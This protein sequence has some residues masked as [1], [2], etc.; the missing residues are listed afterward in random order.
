MTI[1]WLQRE[2]VYQ[3]P[4]FTVRKDTLRLPDGKQ[5]I[6]DVIDH[7]D[8]VTILPIDEEGNILFVRQYRQPIED[9][10]LELPAGV[11]KPGEDPLQCAQRELREET[12]MGANL[13]TKLGTFYLAPGYSSEFMHVYLARDLYPSPL[14]QDEDEVLEL[15]KIPAREALKLAENGGLQDLKSLIGLFWAKSTLD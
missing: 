7:L 8:S 5:V 12:G 4:V 14:P 6:V 2:I 3:G 9:Y 15:E 1:E 10:L 13:F 11:A